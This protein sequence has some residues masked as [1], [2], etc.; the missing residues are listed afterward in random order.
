MHFYLE[1]TNTRM[2]YYL[3]CT[4][5]GCY[6]VV[7]TNST[8]LQQ[9]QITS[10]Y[11]NYVLLSSMYITSTVYSSFKNA[12]QLACTAIQFAV[13]S[14][15]T[16]YNVLTLECTTNYYVILYTASWHYKQ[17]ALLQQIQTISKYFNQSVLLSSMYK[18]L[19]S[20][21]YVTRTIYKYG[22]QPVCTSYFVGT[23]NSLHYLA[24]INPF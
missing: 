24:N 16:V 18:V 11:S 13:Q 10:K 21:M 6:L 1:C 19:L 12:Q 22:L 20:S 9:I 14:C 2:F 3:V 17:L 8:L 15:T 4:T 23:S 7:T 5:M